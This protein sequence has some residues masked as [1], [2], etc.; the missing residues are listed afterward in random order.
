MPASNLRRKLEATEASDA[1]FRE[2]RL[3]LVA[4]QQVCSICTILACML[5]GSQILSRLGPQLG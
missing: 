1:F 5:I 4:V 3:V 2:L